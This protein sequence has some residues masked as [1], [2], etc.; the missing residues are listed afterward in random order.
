MTGWASRETSYLSD[1]LNR[2][3]HV[4]TSDVRR[5]RTDTSDKAAESKDAAARDRAGT[6]AFA[7]IDKSLSIAHR[8]AVTIIFVQTFSNIPVV[9][10]SLEDIGSILLFLLYWSFGA[11]CSLLSN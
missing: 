10:P 3:R 7:Q 5:Q 11:N 2:H 8:G 1:S 9:Y 4:G 6:R